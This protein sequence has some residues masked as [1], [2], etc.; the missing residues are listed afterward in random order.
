MKT[1]TVDKLAEQS[2]LKRGTIIQ[3]FDRI[4]GGFMKDGVRLFPEGTRYPLE[5]TYR[6]KDAV[7]R[8]YVILLALSK[9]RYVDEKYLKVSEESF[10]TY[11]AELLENKLIRKRKTDNTLGTN[12]YELTIKGCEFIKNN[13]RSSAAKKALAD[14]LSS[15]ISK[16]LIS[17]A[18]SIIN[19]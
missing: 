12:G 6:V 15:V 8:Y 18:G 3:N 14:I 2:D 10:E 9:N 11:L 4:P 13:S 17:A 5:K 16:A 19:N 1:L 7:D